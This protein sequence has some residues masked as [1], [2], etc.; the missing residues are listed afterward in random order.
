MEAELSKYQ[1]QKEAIEENLTA[2]AEPAALSV[3]A[4]ALGMV[5]SHATGYIVLKE[6]KVIG[7]APAA[8]AP[9]SDAAP[10]G[11]AAES[12]VAETT[13]TADADADAAAAGAVTEDTASGATDEDTVPAADSTEGVPEVTP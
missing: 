11:T 4:R 3:Q 10:D 1:T 8:A 9:K 6:G 2:L 5:P 13:V 12:T 7:D